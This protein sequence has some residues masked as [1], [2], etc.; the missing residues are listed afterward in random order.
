MTTLLIVLFLLSQS[1][2]TISEADSFVVPFIDFT[3]ELSDLE[4]FTQL[5]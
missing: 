5:F 3:H 1:V 2:L 4:L